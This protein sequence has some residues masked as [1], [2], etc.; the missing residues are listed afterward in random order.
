MKAPSGLTSATIAKRTVTLS[1]PSNPFS[2]TSQTDTVTVNG[3]VTT[4]VYQASTK[5]LTTTSAQGRQS[6]TT[7]DSAGR[8][9]S[10]RVG[11]LT[12]VAYSYDDRGRLA[13]VAQGARISEL[14]CDWDGNLASITDP[15]GRTTGFEVDFAGR[16]TK[17]VLPD[18][19]EIAF[20]YDADDN[21]TSITPPGRPAH[22]FSYTPVNLQQAYTP[23]DLGI[24]PVATTYAYNLDKQ[25]TRITRPD[26]ADVGFA[27]DTTGRLATITAPHGATSFA[28]DPTKGQLSTNTTPDSQQLAYTYDGFLETGVAWSGTVSGSV[29]RTYNTDFRVTQTKVN[30]AD[31][32]AFTYDS[33]G[34]LTGAGGLTLTRDAANGLLTASS[35]GTVSDTRTSSAYGEPESYTASVGGSDVLATAFTRDL[36]GRIVEKVETIQGQTTTFGY[37]YDTAGRLWQVTKTGPD[38]VPLATT[39]AY[40][41]NRS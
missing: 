15:T 9:V 10:E 2:L 40:D 20:T 38:G 27:Y 29:S 31:P 3:K 5:R 18:G 26:G 35:I 33:D 19:R 21:V 4:T 30:G 13:T 36:L 32:V 34:L 1:T 17:Q 11:S 14:A 28:Y 16:V 8:T 37:E 12:P 39:Y 24:G 25:L 7:L 22:L 6:L 23:P 41:S